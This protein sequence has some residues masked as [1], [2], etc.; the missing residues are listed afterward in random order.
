MYGVRFYLEVFNLISKFA[1][2]R[3]V[4]KVSFEN[5]QLSWRRYVNKSHCCFS[6]ETLQ[7]HIDGVHAITYASIYIFLTKFNS[8]TE[9]HIPGS[10]AV[11]SISSRSEDDFKISCNIFPKPNPLTPRQSMVCMQLKFV[12]TEAGSKMSKPIKSIFLPEVDCFQCRSYLLSL[13]A[14]H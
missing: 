11:S 9:S 5:V 13:F 10:E 4:L 14:L 6:I 3:E 2:I 8:L 12:A 1:K 7:L